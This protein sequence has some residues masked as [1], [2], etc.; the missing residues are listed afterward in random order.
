M[1]QIIYSCLTWLN[2]IGQ[3]FCNYAASMFVQSSVLI[4]LLLIFDFLMR[5]RVKATF[6]YWIWMLVFVKIVLPPSLSLPTG[7]GYWYGD[8]LSADSLVLERTSNIIVQQGSAGIPTSQDLTESVSLPQ[9]QAS[10]VEPKAAA[11]VTSTTP[12]L[13]SL[14]WQAV[15]FSL[16]LVGVLFIL[17]LLIQRMWFVRRLIA[18]SEQASNR[19][20]ERLNQCVRQI[21]IGRNI[22]LRLSQNITSP[23]VCGLFKPKILM[24]TALVGELSPDKL[25]A[26]L[27]HEL[28]HIK[29]GDLWV[30]FVQTVLQIIY[31]YNPF[32]WLANTVVRR[33]REQAVDEMVL[34][35]LGAGAKSY[36]N[37]LIDIAEMAFWKTNLSLRLIG[38]VESKK[39]LHRRIRHMLTRPIPKSAKVGLFGTIVIIIIGS[40]L[41]PM[42]SSQESSVSLFEPVNDQT[43]ELLLKHMKG[44]ADIT[45]KAWN[46]GDIDTLLSIFTNDGIALCD[47][48]EAVMGKGALHKLFITETEKEVKLRSIQ[49]IE[50]QV[51]ICG[52]M[53]YEA[54]KYA[55]SFTAPGT[56]FLFTDYRKFLTIYKRQ[57]DGSLKV[58]LDS[59]N[60]DVIPEATDI[61]QAFDPGA[62]TVV[63]LRSSDIPSTDNMDAVY[64]QIKRHESTFHKTFVERNAEA[65]ARFYADDALLMAQSQGIVRG[66]ADILKH[67]KKGMNESPLV[68]MTQ[69]VV[70]IEGNNQMLFA[71]NLFS[72]TF[73]DTSSGE[74]VTFPGK[75]V[76][77][78]TRLQDGSWKILLD[79]CNVSVP[80]TGK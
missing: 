61:S 59:W 47:Q 29:R 27:I 35:N 78:W 11:P 23:A 16:W 74:N 51:W 79:L 46:K 26:V 33:I 80:I 10:Y 50:Q 55:V 38:V 75:G 1:N 67:I 9:I 57:P 12:G 64:E 5:K 66:K 39:A 77:V 37:T 65:S 60:L 2:N 34:A 63:S 68:D 22:E 17:V 71:V 62:V 45:I 25:R 44:I 13:D 52:D 72:W 36:G 42:A 56:R 6:R 14:S 20:V 54:G 31:F 58:K 7:I 48:A 21:G 40:V 24:P 53:I 41:L 28:A 18:Q 76:H 70:H 3:G 4:V 8:Y 49:G 69:H 32:V 15:V 43:K 73:K 19:L 30:N